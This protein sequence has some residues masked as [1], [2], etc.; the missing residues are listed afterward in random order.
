MSD[1]PEAPS[2]ERRGLQGQALDFIQAFGHQALE[3]PIN[4]A[5]Q[6]TNH[7]TG[8]HLPRLDIIGAPERDSI[9]TRA[10]AVAGIV[11]DLVVVARLAPTSIPRI[12]PL[13]V[14]NI[15]ASATT[16]A[17]YG[18]IF[19]ETN[20]AEQN[21]GR[22]RLSNA[23]VGALSFGTAS[24]TLGRLSSSRLFAAPETRSV[25]GSFALNGTAAA[26]GALV[27][28]ESAAML[29]HGRPATMSELSLNMGTA[30]LFGGTIGAAGRGY[31][32]VFGLNGRPG[33]LAPAEGRA[34]DAGP[35]QQLRL[36]TLEA[37]QNTPRNLANNPGANAPRPLPRTDETAATDHNRVVTR[38]HEGDDSVNR[39]YDHIN[40]LRYLNFAPLEWG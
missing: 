19:T 39:V 14:H 11:A 15:I 2:S 36:N 12:A 25:A 16:G 22:D 13:A 29:W 26:S 31:Q 27:G 28:T 3:S 37:Q 9:G 40:D 35:A 23:A 20:P 4:A 30:A 38:D 21:F 34:P 32:S 24:A 10:G 33:V 7:Y 6:L 18:G 1:R 17:V 5:T 8:T